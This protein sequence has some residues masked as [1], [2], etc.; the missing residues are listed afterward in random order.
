MSTAPK[1]NKNQMTTTLVN[2]A[3]VM[4][5][6]YL[7]LRLVFANIV[8]PDLGAAIMI[9]GIVLLVF[10]SI[11]IKIIITTTSIVLLSMLFAHNTNQP[12]EK[13]LFGVGLIV[14]V[15]IATYLKLKALFGN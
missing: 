12:I 10:R 13:V 15:C 6:I 4:S 2:I 5:I 3:T 8:S 9:G 14:A 7:S 11:L 1:S